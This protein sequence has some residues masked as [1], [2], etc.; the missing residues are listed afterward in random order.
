[1]L[2]EEG[3]FVFKIVLKIYFTTWSAVYL[4]FTCKHNTQKT[5]NLYQY[6]HTAGS[7]IPSL[8]LKFET[9]QIPNLEALKVSL[10]ISF[11]TLSIE[12]NIS[13]NRQL[14]PAFLF[15]AP[16]S[17]CISWNLDH[18]SRGAEDVHLR[19][20]KRIPEKWVLFNV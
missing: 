13:E 5:L 16:L 15:K 14:H 9:S 7:S 12:T 20:R 6:N 3:K 18:C 10:L 8:W 19:N 4:S 11:H 2:V 1:M 17:V